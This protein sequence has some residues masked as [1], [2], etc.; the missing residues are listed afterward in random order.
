[1]MCSTGTDTTG[2]SNSR[3][4][5]QQWQMGNAEVEFSMDIYL[6]DLST[7]GE[8]YIINAGLYDQFNSAEGNNGFYLEYDRTNSV[9]WVG[10]T[11]GGGSVTRTDT[12]VVVAADEWI[13]VRARINNDSTLAEFWVNDTKV[14]ATLNIPTG[15]SELSNLAWVIGKSAGT[16]ARSAYFTNIHLGV[17]YDA[18]T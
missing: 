17:L 16:T 1:M 6:P 2:Y 18:L 9:N 3:L 10:V 11:A 7:A 15:A 8:E 14:S 13:N 4:G 5:Y 12:G